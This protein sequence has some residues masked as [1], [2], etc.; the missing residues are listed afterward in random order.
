MPTPI[1][2]TKFSRALADFI[3]FVYYRNESFLLLRGNKAVAEIRPVS[4]NMSL[5]DLSV[6]LRGGS[7]LSKEENL[8]FL[9]DVEDIKKESAKD[10]GRNKWES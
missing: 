5:G 8:D 10:R 6:L 2:I 7:G 4:K 3:N 9:R 1:T